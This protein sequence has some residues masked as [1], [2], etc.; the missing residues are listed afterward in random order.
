MRK[1]WIENLRIKVGYSYI[2]YSMSVR[3]LLLILDNTLGMEKQMNAICKS[4]CYK[5]RNV[6]LI[7][8]YINNETCKTLVK[9]LIISRLEYFISLYL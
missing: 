9:S 6:G 3:N 5:V 1:Q 7:F 8:K 4:C 2:N